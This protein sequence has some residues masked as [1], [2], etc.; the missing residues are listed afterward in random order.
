LFGDGW[1]ALLAVGMRNVTVDFL[2]RVGPGAYG[3]SGGWRS[4]SMR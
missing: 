4:L 3:R 1:R 2:G